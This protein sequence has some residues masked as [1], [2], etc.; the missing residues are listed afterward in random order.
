MIASRWKF[1]SL[2][3]R[4]KA[5]ALRDGGFFMSPVCLFVCRQRT[6]T[7]VGAYRV[8]TVKVKVKVSVFI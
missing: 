6:L 3:P 1:D 7:T 5:G 4:R 2:S 8:G